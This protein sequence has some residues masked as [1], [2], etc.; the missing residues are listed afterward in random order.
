MSNLFYHNKSYT[1]SYLA[2]QHQILWPVFLIP[3]TYAGVLF[4]IPV[5]RLFTVVSFCLVFY[6]VECIRFCFP[7]QKQ[8]CLH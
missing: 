8:D 3:K 6:I 2:V 7:F 4:S 5:T 1:V